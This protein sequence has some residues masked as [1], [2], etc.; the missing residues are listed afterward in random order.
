MQRPIFPEQPDFDRFS[1]R[2]EELR[3]VVRGRDPIQLAAHTGASHQWLD[4]EKSEFYLPLW[5]RTIRLTFPGLTAYLGSSNA[6]LPSFQLA[7]TLYYFATADGSPL[8]QRWI[9]FSD[10]PDGRFYNQAYQGY[11]GY[12]LVRCFGN[13]R[14]AFDQAAIKL[15]GVHQTFG[16]SAFSFLALP[17][18]PILVVLWQGDEDFSA[19]YQ[20]LFD[21][22]ANHYLPTDAYA[23]LGS[24]LTSRLIKLKQSSA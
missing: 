3:S 5:E 17:R 11:T 18:V 19:S 8:M 4:E 23:I 21:A 10:L 22:S 2:V 16:D 20:I 6:T 15:G 24:T 12:E 14:S 1:Q 7:L 9:S 13:D